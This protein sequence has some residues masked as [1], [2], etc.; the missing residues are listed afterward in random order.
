MNYEKARAYNRARSLAPAA[1]HALRDCLGRD[2]SAWTD[3]DLM[4]IAQWQALQGLAADGMVGP[5]TVKAVFA[6]ATQKTARRVPLDIAQ[7]RALWAAA[8][9]LFFID[10]SHHQRVTDWNLVRES[11]DGVVIKA[12]QG[13][14]TRDKKLVQH[15]QFARGAGVK[16]LALYHYAQH[17][18][19]TETTA[20]RTSDPMTGAQNLV[21]ACREHGVKW[22][23]LDLEPD[24]V[25][26]A[27]EAGWTAAQFEA[28]SRAFCAEFLRSGLRLVVYL[29]G[30]TVKRSRGG[31]AS[32]GFD[33]LAESGLPLWWA[34]YLD[35]DDSRPD[36]W[37][38]PVG[39][40]KGWPT[41]AAHQYRGG[42][43]KKT[44][45]DEGGK[46]PG[47]AGDVDCN[48]GPRDGWV[49]EMWRDA[50]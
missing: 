15:V 44:K 38:L 13:E 27:R 17:V 34:G 28:W 5:K 14:S 45:P 10:I 39:H 18:G 6:A 11:C 33:W 37:G 3:A 46:C 42:D 9:L 25:R 35:H 19:H 20:T 32:G 22:G 49:G 29:S 2:V 24:E 50:A 48:C 4:A 26:L 21:R 7:T 43:D 36:G 1:L 47:I 8:A 40:I 41:D 23:V 16:V 30:E 12:T 31:A